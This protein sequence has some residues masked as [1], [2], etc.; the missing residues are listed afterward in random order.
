MSGHGEVGELKQ[1]Y[2]AGDDPPE[3]ILVLTARIFT[4][5]PWPRRTSSF[6]SP[7]GTTWQEAQAK[8]EEIMEL[9]AHEVTVMRLEPGQRR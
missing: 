3:F 9:G 1:I 2:V 5:L 7:P 8:A 6:E 4:W